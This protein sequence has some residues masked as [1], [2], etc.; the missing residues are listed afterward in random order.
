LCNSDYQDQEAPPLPTGQTNTIKIEEVARGARAGSRLL[1]ALE[2]EERS[3]V[4]RNMAL[5]L[6]QR[7]EDILRVNAEDVDAAEKRCVRR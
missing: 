6:E 1:Q 7:Q 5:A 2:S 4:L 3:A